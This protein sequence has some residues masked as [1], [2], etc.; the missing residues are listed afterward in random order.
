MTDIQQEV[1]MCVRCWGK[2]FTAAYGIGSKTQAGE[3]ERIVASCACTPA[4][5][6]GV[7]DSFAEGYTAREKEIEELRARVKGL[8]GMVPRPCPECGGIGCVETYRAEH[9]SGCTDT[10]CMSSCPQPVQVMVHCDHCGGNGAIMVPP[11]PLPEAKPSEPNGQD[12]NG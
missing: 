4:Q 3:Y 11:I 10:R 2:A 12:S 6:R 1:G 8:E 7:S 5:R 9:A